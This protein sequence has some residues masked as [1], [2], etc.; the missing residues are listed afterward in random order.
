[1]AVE[2]CGCGRVWLWRCVA[3]EVCGCG[4]WRWKGVVVEGY[5][6]GGVWRWKGVAVE[7]YVLGVVFEFH[8]TL[9]LMSRQEW[10]ECSCDITF[11]KLLSVPL[12]LHSKRLADY[13]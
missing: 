6:C 3:V 7:V 9:I 12:L 8:C 5:G 4:V 11:S 13:D 1:V 2:V 10:D